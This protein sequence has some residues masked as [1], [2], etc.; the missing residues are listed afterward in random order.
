MTHNYDFSRPIS[1]YRYISAVICVKYI[2]PTIHPCTPIDIHI[3]NNH[4]A[5]SKRNMVYRMLPLLAVKT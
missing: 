1:C 5:Y 2:L 4:K 3:V